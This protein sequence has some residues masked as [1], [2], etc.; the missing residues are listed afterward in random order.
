[1]RKMRCRFCHNSFIPDPRVEDR[2]KSCG[3]PDCQKALK[4]EYLVHW[5]RKNPKY[6][7]EDYDRLKNWLAENPGYL[8]TYRQTHPE[9]AA[10]NRTAQKQRDRRKKS[11]LDIETQLKDQLRDIVKQLW[12]KPDLDIQTPIETQPLKIALLLGSLACLDI[13]TP[14][15]RPTCFC[16]HGPKS[17]GG[18]PY[19]IPPTPGP[20]AGP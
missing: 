8:K 10:K 12:E 1:M 7:Q 5:R 6:F 4:A 14:I 19:A 20:A 17:K 2:Q 16:H 9:Y 18:G 13:Q 3:R 15:D 11:R